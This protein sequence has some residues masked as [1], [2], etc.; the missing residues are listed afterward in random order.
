MRGAVVFDDRAVLERRMEFV[1]RFDR[2]RVRLRVNRA[3]HGAVFVVRVHQAHDLLAQVGHPVKLV[4]L[5]LRRGDRQPPREQIVAIR[6]IHAHAR[7]GQILR[8]HDSDAERGRLPMRQAPVHGAA[9]R[10]FSEVT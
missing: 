1:R 5:R 3:E 8:R 10:S 4:V 2:R 7:S 9:L 6:K